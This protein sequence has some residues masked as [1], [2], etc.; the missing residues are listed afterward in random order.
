MACVACSSSLPQGHGAGC[1][2]F[3]KGNFKDSLRSH[4]LNVAQ[5]Y[6]GMVFLILAAWRSAPGPPEGQWAR[7]HPAALTGCCSARRQFPSTS[8][9]GWLCARW[10]DPQHRA[11]VRDS[12]LC[13]PAQGQER[14]NAEP[15]CVSWQLQSTAKKAMGKH[16]LLES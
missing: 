13:L 6:L 4:I 1:C 8:T 5:P 2:C 7:F 14:L 9:G 11:C 15:M 12:E 10:T 3:S 16:D